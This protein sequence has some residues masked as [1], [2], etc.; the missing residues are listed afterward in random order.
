MAID[1]YINNSKNKV[2]AT[3]TIVRSELG[4]DKGVSHDIPKIVTQE[5]IV[6]D[7][8]HIVKEFNNYFA[9]LAHNVREVSPSPQAALNKLKANFDNSRDMQQD[10][11]FKFKL[12]TPLEVKKVISFE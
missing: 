8:A 11:T 1:V 2:K 3:W 10:E 7:K 12:V 9:N 6:T 5:G 4:I